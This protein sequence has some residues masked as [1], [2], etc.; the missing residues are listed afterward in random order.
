MLHLLRPAAVALA[1]LTG[2]L[3]A[4][5]QVATDVQ[6]VHSIVSRVMQGV[7]APQLIVPP[8]ASPHGLALRPSSARLIA[9]ADAII[10][11][12]PA[13]T[14][15]LEGSLAAL[16]E[17][18]VLELT[19]AEGV[20][21]LPLREGG[22]FEAHNHDHG[23]E[24]AH[25]H[26]HDDHASVDAHLWLDPRNGAA[27]ATAV[28]DFLAGIDPANAEIYRTNAATFDAE[29]TALEADLQARL[30][31]VAGRPYIVF[32]DAYQYFEHH[33]DIPAVGSVTLGE[34]DQ[35]SA[36]RVSE[37]RARIRDLNVTCVFAEPQFE[38]RLIATIIEGTGT[39]TATLDPLG[40]A[41][42]PGPDLYPLLLTGL[43]DGL[44]DCL[45]D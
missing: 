31:P 28:A 44:A 12:G 36:A 22:P 18:P 13:L 26:D 8:G 20:T 4:A 29:L 2:P 7:G 9:D 45:G 3:A 6:P 17:A 10:W 23:H 43:A 27:I 32:H 35:P 1:A 5:P 41:L 33:F 40:A 14:P 25:N 37:I 39:R 24:D 38:P 42:E 16:A 19:E 15:W 34:A 11:I 21:L 30:A